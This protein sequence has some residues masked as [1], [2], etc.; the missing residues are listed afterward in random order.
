[1]PQRSYLLTE[2]RALGPELRR[3][4][5]A[6]LG[7]PLFLAQDTTTRLTGPSA[8]AGLTAGMKVAIY[9]DGAVLHTG[10]RLR[11]DRIIRER[12]R[13]GTAAW[14]VVDLTARDLG[15]KDRV[16]AQRR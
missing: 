12:L 13:R 9:V 6:A 11:R 5:W 8:R 16:V 7:K 2:L 15:A 3:A 4:L 10:H 1:M 14:R